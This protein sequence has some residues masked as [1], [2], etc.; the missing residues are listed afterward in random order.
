MAGGRS[1]YVLVLTREPGR[2][3]PGARPSQRNDRLR[4]DVKR[5]AG[6]AM[7]RDRRRDTDG[8]S[9]SRDAQRRFHVEDF[10]GRAAR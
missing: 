1:G 2:R 5:I 10:R 6:H 7:C 8:L 4:S 9:P 3:H